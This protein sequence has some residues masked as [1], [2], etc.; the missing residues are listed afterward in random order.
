MNHES[1]SGLKALVVMT[2][3]DH[4]GV[5]TYWKDAIQALDTDAEWLFFV[6]EIPG[7]DPNPFQRTNVRVS[8]RL[9]WKNPLSSSRALIQEVSDFHPDCLVL[10]ATLAVIR[11]LPALIFLRIFQPKLRIKCVFH[12]GAI[13][14]EA[15][16]DFINRLFV[17]MTTWLCHQNI[18]VSQFVAN[19]WLCSGLVVSRP[20]FPKARMSYSLTKPP[21][22][23]FLGRISHEKDPELYLRVMDLVRKHL[24]VQV[25]IG[26]VGPLKD[27]LEHDFPWAYWR[28]WVKPQEW[29]QGIDLL[30]CTSKTEGWPIAIGEAL[31]LGVPT[32]GINVGGVGEVVKGV[33]QR[34]L[35]KTREASQLAELVLEFMSNYPGHAERYFKDL[36]TPGITF[37]DWALRL[38][39]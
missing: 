19:Y 33:D 16:K 24:Q 10:N 8:T 38:L 4:G 1:I 7:V 25:D 13:Y 17:S 5:V 6:N 12:N 39:K 28:G 14:Q 15:F 18:F 2:M 34:W 35:R 32:I 3:F 20:F 27:Q 21:T 30:V 31:E 9:D 22:I 37:R 23:G 26:G 11:I 36:N 29:L